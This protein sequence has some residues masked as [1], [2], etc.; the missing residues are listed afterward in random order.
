VRPVCI[1]LLAVG[2]LQA[3]EI[4][5]YSEFERFDPFGR[6]VPQDCDLKIRELL[7]PAVPRNGHLSVHVV[8]TAPAGT[9]YFLYAAQSPLG[10]LDVKVYREHFARCGDAWCPDF[11]TEQRAP[12]FGAMP[13]NARTLPD[14]T[15]R[16]YLF[17]IHVPADVPPR[18]VRVEALLKTGIWM[19]APLEIR[20]ID[21]VIPDMTGLPVREDIAP[22][23]ARSSDTAQRQLLRFLN[24]LPP[25]RPAGL[26]RIRDF[27]QRNAAEDMMVARTRGIR[28]PELNLMS[29]WP[30]TFPDL[31]GEWYLRVRD[32]IYR[33]N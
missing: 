1:L 8:V 2:C 23:E 24:G 27:I 30:Y 31:G 33:Y 11:V 3:Q 15:T 28:G 32:F 13:E 19:V 5:V 29:W 18:R 10:V 17:D 26:L 7:S 4:N 21:P 14:Q 9:N 22:I 20:V 16:C 6:P 25:E 12:A